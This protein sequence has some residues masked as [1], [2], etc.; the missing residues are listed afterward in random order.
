MINLYYFIHENLKIGFKIT[1]EGHNINHGNSILTNIPI[2]SD[3]GIETRF[4]NEI[5]QE[6]AGYYLR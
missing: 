2:Y 6:M 5:L 4:S 3:F 1:L